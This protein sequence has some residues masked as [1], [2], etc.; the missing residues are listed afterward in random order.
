MEEAQA[1]CLAHNRPVHWIPAPG[2]WIHSDYQSCTA[3]WDAPSS[4]LALPR[5]KRGDVTHLL[6]TRS[7]Y[8]VQAAFKN[9]NRGK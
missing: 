1:C 2:W 3:M 7:R 4:V 9:G 8:A 5:L 6:L